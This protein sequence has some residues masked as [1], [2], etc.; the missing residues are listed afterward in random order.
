MR[1]RWQ[2]LANDERGMSL[3]FVGMTFIALLSATTIAIDVGMFM[4]AKTQAQTSADAGALAGATALAFNSFTNRTPTGPAVQSAVNT[5]LANRVI[6]APVSVTSDDVSFPLDPVTAQP[7]RVQVNVYRTADRS[8]SVPTLMGAFF[9]VQ[10][11][12]V[13]AT[14]I[15]EAAPANAISCVKPFTIP[16]RWIEHN[17]PPWNSTTSTFDRYYAN[18]NRRGQVI[19]PN[20]DEYPV[21]GDPRYNGYS[22]TGNDIGTLLTIRAAQ[23]QNVSPSMY[24]SWAMPSMTGADDYRGNIAGCNPTIVRRGT[25][26][27]QEPGAMAGPTADGINDLL[28]Q[29]PHAEWSL[30]CNCV[31][32]SA[33][34]GHS[35]RVFPIP[36]Y[37]PD[38]YQ[39]GV[40]NGRTATLRVANWIGFFLVSISNNGDILGRITP[41]LGMVDPT[42]DPAPPDSLARAIR[43]V[44]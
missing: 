9:G 2:H 43:L 22:M 16:D 26:I 37:D 23:G 25:I 35:P 1:P 31:I 36:L 21:A 41:I 24:F 6:A 28:L 20:P 33:F 4:T 34:P 10:R 29:D 40:T 3:V 12:N 14:A 17:D 5:A 7:D 27:E 32:N 39:G 42:A 11:V 13:A 44:Q 38:F 19:S 30:D 15:A 18:G 8:N